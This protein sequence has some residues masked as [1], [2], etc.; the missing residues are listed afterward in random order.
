MRAITKDGDESCLYVSIRNVDNNKVSGQYYDWKGLILMVKLFGLLMYSI[1]LP[2]A[3]FCI[4]TEV[5]NSSTFESL[6]IHGVPIFL[7][8]P[9]HWW[10]IIRCLREARHDTEA[11]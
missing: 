3:N 7:V 10:I 9:D 1:D 5:N 4:L 11:D 2:S 6:D 8:P